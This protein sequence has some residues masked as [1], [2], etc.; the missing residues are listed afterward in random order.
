MEWQ[1]SVKNLPRHDIEKS[2]IVVSRSIQSHIEK[3]RNGYTEK[4]INGHIEKFKI[5]IS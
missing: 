3:S 5:L 1:K 2:R 4:S